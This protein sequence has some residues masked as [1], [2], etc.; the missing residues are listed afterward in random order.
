L[1]LS[2][3]E[4]EAN[5]ADNPAVFGMIADQ[6]AGGFSYGN[7][8]EFLAKHRQKLTP[9]VKPNA[10]ICFDDN[11]A[12]QKIFAMVGQRLKTQYQTDLRI[13]EKQKAEQETLRK[14]PPDLVG[15]GSYIQDSFPFVIPFLFRRH[16]IPVGENHRQ[17]H[18]Y[19]TGG[20]G[21]GKSEVI[22]SF[23]WHY[24]T[25]NTYSGL[26]L[27]DPHGTLSEQVA[28]FK[29]NA[30]NERLI[31][32]DPAIDH[33]HFPCL[34]PFDIEDKESMGDI[35]AENYAEEFSRSYA[36]TTFENFGFK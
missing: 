17:K 14:Y 28:M 19:I 7:F 20:S 27:I 16:L 26:V 15:Y 23:L 36:L 12:K 8:S 25:R 11:P 34:N 33:K 6:E 24:L 31:Y 30:E 13:Y 3:I 21:S 35:P 22:K 29:P 2:S 18:T 9:P 10:P 4:I 1:R 5:T 32:I